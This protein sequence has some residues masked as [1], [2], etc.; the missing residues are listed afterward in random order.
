MKICQGKHVVSRWNLFSDKS[1]RSGG[2]SGL[3]VIFRQSYLIA[4]NAPSNAWCVVR[5]LPFAAEIN[6][7]LC[8]ES[9]AM[10][11]VMA[12][13]KCRWPGDEGPADG[14]RDDGCRRVDICTDVSNSH[15]NTGAHSIPLCS[16]TRAHAHVRS[17][18]AG[19]RTHVVGW[20]S[21]P[22]SAK[23]NRLGKWLPSWRTKGGRRVRRILLFLF[24]TRPTY[25]RHHTHTHTHPFTGRRDKNPRVPFAPG[26]ISIVTLCFLPFAHTAYAARRHI[27]HEISF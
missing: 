5:A 25:H 4:K 6:Q 2:N 14:G 9:F 24:R 20:V 18:S 23:R 22:E 26:A 19:A 7:K 21:W 15:A 10:C 3:H 13:A 1:Q 8:A 12:A 16:E 27:R 17:A 11:V